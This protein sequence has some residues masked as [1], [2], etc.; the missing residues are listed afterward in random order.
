LSSIQLGVNIPVPPRDSEFD[1][2]S[3]ADENTIN[4]GKH[5]ICDELLPDNQFSFQDP[6]FKFE[7][8]IYP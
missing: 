6:N 3:I 5:L 8:I 7:P 1:K 4:K 2:L